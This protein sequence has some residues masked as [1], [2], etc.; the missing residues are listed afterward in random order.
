MNAQRKTASTEIAT[1]YKMIE[2]LMENYPELRCDDRALCVR[3][4]KS[5][6]P[7]CRWS[8]SSIDGERII[9]W[10]LFEQEFISGRLTSSES[11]CRNARQIRKAH[12]WKQDREKEQ[13]KVKM[14]FR[15]NL[16]E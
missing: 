9:L 7:F 10:N 15:N 16:F 12:G 5:E 14:I 2:G 6:M 4:W 8:K 11:I 3:V 13:E 1:T